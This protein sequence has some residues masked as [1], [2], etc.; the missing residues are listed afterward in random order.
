M[1]RMGFGEGTRLRAHR[2][3]GLEPGAREI[4][5]WASP[6]EL[7]KQDIIRSLRDRLL[8]SRILSAF[9]MGEQAL[10][11]Y[12]AF[13]QRYRPEKMYGY[14]SAF[15]LLARYVESTA[16]RPPESLRAIFTTAEPLFDFQ[17]RTIEAVFDCPAAV[18]YGARDGGLIA[19]ECRDGGLHIPVEGMHVEILGDRG[20]GVGEIV[21]TVLDSFA[22]PIIRYRTGDLGSLEDSPCR[23]GRTL[24]CLK[25]IEGRQTDFLV[26]PD[27]RC[28]HALSVIYPLREMRSVREFRVIQEDLDRVTVTLVPD[29]RFS[30]EDEGWIKRQL[31]LRLGEAIQIDITLVPTL[32]RTPAGKF[33]Y[34]ISKVAGAYLETMLSKPTE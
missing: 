15:Y 27:G 32:S 12:A 34:V 11:R 9:D 20:D 28:L 24:P 22:F 18:E 4:V 33:R 10:A 21:V 19:N 5:L 23:C 30:G 13:I 25:S 16:W 7:T 31:A 17:R 26:T 1:E 6:V 29:G 3:F 14:A 8:N 2:W